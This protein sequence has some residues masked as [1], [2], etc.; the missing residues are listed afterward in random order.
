ML[1]HYLWI[2]LAIYGIM[3]IVVMARIC[4]VKRKLHFFDSLLSSLAIQANF[5][6]VC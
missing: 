6:V 1:G 4:G 5:T 2:R 3:L